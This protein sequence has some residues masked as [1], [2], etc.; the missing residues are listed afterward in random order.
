MIS[1]PSGS[2]TN[3]TPQLKPIRVLLVGMPRMQIDIVKNILASQKEIVVVGETVDPSEVSRAVTAVKAN[4]VVISEAAVPSSYREL[5]YRRPR[6]RII[7][8]IAD[9]RQARVHHLQ[10]DVATILDLSPTSLV[11]AI[12][13]TDYLQ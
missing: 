10:P 4:V 9:G 5:L 12:R 1:A 7:A 11:A 13:G 2:E 3:G 6:L 8:I